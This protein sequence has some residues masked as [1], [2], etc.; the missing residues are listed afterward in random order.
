V[1][2]AAAKA[3]ILQHH[4]SK[5]LPATRLRYG[6]IDRENGALC[7]VAV[8]S[9]PMGAAVL[10]GVFPRLEPMVESV[11]LGRFAL[12]DEVPANAESWMLARVFHLAALMGV[13]GVVSCSDPMPRRSATGAVLTPGTS[14][15]L[16]TASSYCELDERPSW[17]TEQLCPEVDMSG[18]LLFAA[19]RVGC[20]TRL[21]ELVEVYGRG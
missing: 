15:L 3:F 9:V 7:G 5:S 18:A 2:E 10:T 12:L 6:L 17:C 16:C 8:L 4:Y 1:P 20:R 14:A 21:D 13:R 11:E 19:V